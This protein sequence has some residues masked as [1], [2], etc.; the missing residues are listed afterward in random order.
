MN[1][2]AEAALLHTG[3]GGAEWHTA[4][5]PPE[6]EVQAVA[7]A[8]ELAQRTGCPLTLVH[9]SLAESLQRLRQ[10]RVGREAQLDGEVC[11][12]HLFGSTGCCDGSYEA[13]LR[14]I[15]SPPIRSASDSAALLAG[16]ARGDLQFLSTDHCE[17]DLATKLA[18]ARRGFPA[19]PNGVGGVGERLTF[20]YGLAVVSGDL[21]PERWIQICCEEPAVRMGLGG[22]KGRLAP[23]Y[24][25]DVVLFDPV[26]DFTWEPLGA[27]DRDGSLWRGR[28]GQGRVEHVWR[29][30]RLVV[31]NR[32][33]QP[34]LESGRFLAR[35]LTG[36]TGD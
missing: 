36:T 21:T 3:R 8:L 16:L 28:R 30:G 1:A 5:H 25:A 18:A 15:C 29:R 4:A 17:F 2:A 32:A 27:S 19:I 26:V 7:T 35:R 9:L 22:T 12:H 10:A 11:L 24:D 23:G 6:S 33:L 20:T 34:D 13:T 31:R 14:I